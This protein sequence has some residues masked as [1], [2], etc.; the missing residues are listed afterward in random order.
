[1]CPDRKE[2]KRE[3]QPREQEREPVG[4]L[5]LHGRRPLPAAP[6][7]NLVDRIEDPGHPEWREEAEEPARCPGDEEEGPRRQRGHEEGTERAP[8]CPFGAEP[9]G[10][11][12]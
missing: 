12:A 9:L 5:R 2:Q 1:E 10:Y 8:P 6:L 4:H 7:Q 11:G 3:V